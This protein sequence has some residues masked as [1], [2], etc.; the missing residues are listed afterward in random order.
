MIP[1]RVMCC[2]PA[3]L[4]GRKVPEEIS[5]VGID[6]DPLCRGA[7]PLADLFGYAGLT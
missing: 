6:N 7:C 1:V 2:R 3:M 5:I 4:L